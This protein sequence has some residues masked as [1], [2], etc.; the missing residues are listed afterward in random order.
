VSARERRA[1]YADS[2]FA[3]HMRSPEAEEKGWCVVD[4]VLFVDKG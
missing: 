2:V 1:L 4:G 3:F